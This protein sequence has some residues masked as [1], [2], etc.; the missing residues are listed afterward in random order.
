MAMLLSSLRLF[1]EITSAKHMDQPSQ[2]AILHVFNLL[3]RF[4]PAIRA[5]DT[6]MS[7]KSPVPSERAALSQA[8]YEVLKDIVPDYLVKSDVKR[9]M[10]GARLLLGLILEKS[11]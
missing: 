2:D 5:V 8:L 9:Y 3:T 6:L 7:G 1:S 10:E 4:P 11:K